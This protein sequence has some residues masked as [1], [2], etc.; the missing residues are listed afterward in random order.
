MNAKRELVETTSMTLKMFVQA[1]DINRLEESIVKSVQVD[2]EPFRKELLMYVCDI[3]ALQPY[4][5]HFAHQNLEK[6]TPVELLYLA[7]RCKSSSH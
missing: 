6:L 3:A 2:I 7:K 5:E 4:I 1:V